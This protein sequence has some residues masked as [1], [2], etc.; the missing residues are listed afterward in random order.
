MDLCDVCSEV[1]GD[2]EIANP[3]RTLAFEHDGECRGTWDRERMAQ[4]VANL[5][6][7]A[8]KYGKPDGVIR[9][10]LHGD[11]DKGVRLAVHNHGDPIPPDVLPTIFDPFRR[12][13]EQRE[14]AESL[15]LGLFIVSEIVRSHDGT[16][17]VVSNEA[18]GTTFT[19]T[20]PRVSSPRA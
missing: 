18:E 17:D 10:S 9:V 14:R 5:V 7:N 15:G 6:G 16:I 2:S 20:L 12:G 1:V 8:M 13:G 4:V 11:G 19:V 3:E